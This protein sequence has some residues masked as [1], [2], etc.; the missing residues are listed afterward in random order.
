MVLSMPTGIMRL[1]ARM[2][3]P[4]E[5]VLKAMQ[6]QSSCFRQLSGQKPSCLDEYRRTNL[7]SIKRRETGILMASCNN[8]MDGEFRQNQPLISQFCCN[9]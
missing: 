6:Y 5:A 3:N 2:N 9:G 8:A 1:A 7:R 4:P